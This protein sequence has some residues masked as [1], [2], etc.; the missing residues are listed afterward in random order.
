MNGFLLSHVRKN[1][2]K[3]SAAI[4][5]RPDR[6][7]MTEPY[8]LLR[9]PY[10]CKL[11]MIKKLYLCFNKLL[12]PAP[13]LFHNEKIEAVHEVLTKLLLSTSENVQQAL[14]HIQDLSRIR[15]ICHDAAGHAAQ[16]DIKLVTRILEPPS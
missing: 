6:R 12:Y 7:F 5:L 11:N 3:N 2:E 16:K 10:G 4:L 8:D 9:Q 15:I 14:I 13:I 1:T